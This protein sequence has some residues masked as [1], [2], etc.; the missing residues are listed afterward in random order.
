MHRKHILNSLDQFQHS[1]WYDDEDEKVIQQF[2]YFIKNH[3]SCFD[4]SLDV[5]HLTASCWLW[6][7]EQDACLFTLHKKLKRWLQLGG[8]ADGHTN[9]LEVA[10][11]EALEESGIENISAVSKEIFDI[12]IHEIPAYKTEQAHLHYDVRYILKVNDNSLFKISSESED[13]K[14]IKLDQFDQ[15]KF[16]PSILRMKNKLVY[17]SSHES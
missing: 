11:K 15:Y 8:H 3:P 4:R 12:S 2:Y 7:L 14:W 17:S 1:N 16:D 9:L 5:G 13:L 10:L 6:N